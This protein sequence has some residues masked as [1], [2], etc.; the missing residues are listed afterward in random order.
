M[1]CSS[2]DSGRSCSYR[3]GRTGTGDGKEWRKG[4]KERSEKGDRRRRT[5]SARIVE[6]RQDDEGGGGGE[7]NGLGREGERLTRRAGEMSKGR[8]DSH[9]GDN[10]VVCDLI[11]HPK[12]NRETEMFVQRGTQV[13]RS[14]PDERE[15]KREVEASSALPERNP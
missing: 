13:R 12:R 4:G 6:E 8:N 14:L 3:P 9:V 7:D 1:T 10:G 11:I 2:V 5:E 15:R